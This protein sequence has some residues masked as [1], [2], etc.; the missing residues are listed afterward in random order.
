MIFP[1]EETKLSE[2]E[3]A[4]NFYQSQ[5]RITVERAF[6]MLISKLGIFWKPLQ[7]RLKLIT[8]IIQACGRIHNYCINNGVG[9]C[10]M[11]SMLSPVELQLRQDGTLPEPVYVNGAADAIDLEDD[12]NVGNPSR[13]IILQGI[14]VN[15]C[16]R[17]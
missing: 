7:F 16:K 11:G 2:E 13:A 4:F 1:L 10:P 12:I 6:G 15:G 8:K 3:D 17:M 9:C 14:A 5:V